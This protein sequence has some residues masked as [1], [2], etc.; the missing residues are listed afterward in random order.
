M[1]YRVEW[2]ETVWHAQII[3]VPDDVD[4]VEEYIAEPN[5]VDWYGADGIVDCEIDDVRAHTV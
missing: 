5:N 1:K 2:T 4:D 3:N